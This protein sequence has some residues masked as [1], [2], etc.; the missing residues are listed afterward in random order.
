[1]NILINYFLMPSIVGLKKDYSKIIDRI[2]GVFKRNKN[3]EDK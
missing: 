1:M 3:V 2:K